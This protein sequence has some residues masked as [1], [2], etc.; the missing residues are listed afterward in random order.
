MDTDGLTEL[1]IDTLTDGLTD[2]LTDGL[3]ELEI[4]GLVD[5]EIDCEYLIVMPLYTLTNALTYQYV[6]SQTSFA[7]S[8]TTATPSANS[9]WEEATMA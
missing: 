6:P 7:L 5:G 3:A 2:K 8:P 4:D 1:D 9:I